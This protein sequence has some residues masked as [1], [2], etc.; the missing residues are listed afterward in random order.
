MSLA[1]ACKRK[2]SEN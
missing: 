1:L 2:K